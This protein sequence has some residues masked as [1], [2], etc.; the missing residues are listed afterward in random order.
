[1]EGV[2]GVAPTASQIARGGPDKNAGP[3]YVG[4]LSLD[5]FEDLV[6]FH[7]LPAWLSGAANAL[8]GDQGWLRSFGG[9]LFLGGL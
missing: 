8:P 1:V 9:D 2:S 7:G 5:A 3:P 4:R 6:D